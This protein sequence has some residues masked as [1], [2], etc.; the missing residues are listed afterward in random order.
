LRPWF[1]ASIAGDLTDIASTI[2]GHGELPEGAVAA[3]AA[4]AGASALLS[5]GL[6]LTLP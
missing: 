2:A 5:A 4:V 1:A 6:A 3:T